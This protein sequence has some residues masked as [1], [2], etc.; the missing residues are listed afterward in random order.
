MNSTKGP[1][2]SS[3]CMRERQV[4][5]KR[6]IPEIHWRRS[7]DMAMDYDLCCVWSFEMRAFGCQP[8]FQLFP[9]S[10]T[11]HLCCRKGISKSKKNPLARVHPIPVI[12]EWPQT[13]ANPLFGTQISYSVE[14]QW[15]ISIYPMHCWPT[16]RPTSCSSFSAREPALA[17]VVQVRHCSPGPQF[18]ILTGE[19]NRTRC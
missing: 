2:F 17:T 5:K 10:Y 16:L 14:M 11:G 13:V 15:Y 6:L 8:S 19:P 3:K 9:G 1:R 7:S 4:L 18:Q 12:L